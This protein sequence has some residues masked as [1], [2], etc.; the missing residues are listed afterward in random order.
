MLGAIALLMRRRVP[1]GRVW[2]LAPAAAAT[3]RFA[4]AIVACKSGGLRAWFNLGG[5]I[6]V[7]LGWGKSQRAR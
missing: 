4:L 3:G 7:R 6:L 5:S 1:D 2:H